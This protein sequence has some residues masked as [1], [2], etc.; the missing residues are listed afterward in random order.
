MTQQHDT[1]TLMNDH[2]NLAAA[3]KEVANL[4]GLDHGPHCVGQI[5][6]GYYE[7]INTT[8]NYFGTEILFIPRFEKIWEII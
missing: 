2:F 3:F 6:V 1:K 7:E 8:G 5:H 4:I